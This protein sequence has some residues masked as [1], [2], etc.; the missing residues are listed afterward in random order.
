MSVPGGARRR[1]WR[2]WA[3]C[4]WAVAVAAGGGLTLWLQDSVRPQE[5][6]VWENGDGSTPGLHG[7]TPRPLHESSADYEC[8]PSPEPT[9]T[10]GP[11]RTV[12]A[13][14]Y[15]TTAP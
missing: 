6:Y 2:R 4:A 5:P 11:S 1:R 13:C 15:V 3:V 12:A 10:Q 8:P 7:S 14:A 9:S